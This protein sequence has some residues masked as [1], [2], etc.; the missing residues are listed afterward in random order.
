MDM[1][2]D[3]DF[4]ETESGR[5][6]ASRCREEVIAMLMDSEQAEGGPG[7]FASDIGARIEVSERIQKQ[8]FVANL[9]H[10]MKKDG[11]IW[12]DGGMYRVVMPDGRIDK[13][14]TVLQSNAAAQPATP[15]KPDLDETEMAIK[16]EMERLEKEMERL[17][18]EQRLDIPKKV[19]G[20][21]AFNHSPVNSGPGSDEEVFAKYADG[22]EF[23]KADAA[24]DSDNIKLTHLDPAEVQA[25]LDRYFD[26]LERLEKRASYENSYKPVRSDAVLTVQFD[27]TI[28]HEQAAAMDWET[29]RRLM[30]SVR[31]LIQAEKDLNT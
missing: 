2:K 5:E 29:W 28:S 17:E 13:A 10:R 23:S 24:N 8:K 14:A 22:I 19:E 27:F 30:D 6:R 12:S 21:K 18:A 4:I 26:R 9:I 1:S 16:K 11:E 31:T 7:L 20:D 15:A 25:S 3:Q